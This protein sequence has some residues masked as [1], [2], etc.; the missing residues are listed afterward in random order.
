MKVVPPS[1]NQLSQQKPRRKQSSKKDVREKEE[2][3][4]QTSKLRLLSPIIAFY[5]LNLL[6]LA[7]AHPT[8]LPEFTSY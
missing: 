4:E 8:I 3:T 7:Q 5:N 1:L 2:R 6:S